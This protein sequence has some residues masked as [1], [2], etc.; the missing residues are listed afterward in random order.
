[1]EKIKL[2]IIGMGNMG[3]GHLNY[4]KNGLCPKIEVTAFADIDAQRLERAKNMQPSAA[5]FSNPIDMLDSGLIDSALIAVPHYGHPEYAIECFKRGIH[6][7]L[8]KPAG[9]KKA[10]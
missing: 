2:G 3:T 6:V 1:M 7:M 5:A 4:I 8:E 10:E 9:V